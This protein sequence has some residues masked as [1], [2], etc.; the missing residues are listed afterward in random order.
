M[1]WDR[2]FPLCV[3]NQV[4]AQ[5]VAQSF[6]LIRDRPEQK[7]LGTPL[8]GNR[9]YV[10]CISDAVAVVNGAHLE[11]PAP[12][13][14][15]NPQL[16][17]GNSTCAVTP[18]GTCGRNGHKLAHPQTTHPFFPPTR[19]SKSSLNQQSHVWGSRMYFSIQAQSKPGPGQLVLVLILV[20]SPPTLRVF[21][22]RI[23]GSISR[24][25]VSPLLIS[26]TASTTLCRWIYEITEYPAAPHQLHP[27]KI[28]GFTLKIQGQQQMFGFW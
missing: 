27:R 8:A 2:I 3:P 25:L 26:I 17:P 4:A 22:S 9:A 12:V 5:G 21:E 11:P 6:L 14:P 20:Q 19:E 13:P 18:G 15:C 7:S 23:Q 16:V 10:P 1:G 24:S 28:L